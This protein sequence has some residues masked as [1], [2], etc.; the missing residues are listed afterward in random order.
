MLEMPGVFFRRKKKKLEDDMSVTLRKVSKP[1]TSVSKMMPDASSVHVLGN[2][3]VAR[4]VRR[5]K[6]PQS[7]RRI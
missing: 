6:Y 4:K 2:G 7:T 3:K 5:P 1:K